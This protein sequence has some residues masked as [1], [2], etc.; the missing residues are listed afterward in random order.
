MTINSESDLKIEVG[1]YDETGATIPVPTYD[2]E[3]EYY[4]H[5]GRS[6]KASQ[7][8]GILTNAV[9]YA[10]SLL[11]V[12]DRPRLGKGVLK[13]R[14]TFHIPDVNFPDKIQTIIVESITDH[15]LV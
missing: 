9:A 4:V 8:N 13:C 2:W 12:F 7:V 10:G 11:L 14:K 5:T 15:I 3:I 1:F 6:V